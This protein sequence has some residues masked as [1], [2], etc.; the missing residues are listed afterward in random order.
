M[1]RNVDSVNGSDFKS[2]MPGPAGAAKT[3]AAGF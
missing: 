2:G 1:A 3:G